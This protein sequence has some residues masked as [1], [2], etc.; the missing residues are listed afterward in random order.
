MDY[1][2]AVARDGTPAPARRERSL[3]FE[4]KQRHSNSRPRQGILRVGARV[5]QTPCVWL[6]LPPHRR[7]HL[8][9][10]FE[11][12]TLLVNAAAIAGVGPKKAGKLISLSK[13]LTA[14]CTLMMDSGGFQIQKSGLI[15]LDPQELLGLY[16]QVAPHLAVVLDHPLSP[17]MSSRDHRRA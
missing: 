8:W 7:P 1:A 10:F 6:G 13:E 14:K 2:E 12:P 16:S 3:S 15:P 4:V 11:N 17:S 9:E 5:I